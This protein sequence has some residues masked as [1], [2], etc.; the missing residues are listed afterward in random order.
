MKKTIS[1]ILALC[2][3]FAFAACGGADEEQ[4]A[5]GNTTLT[6]SW[7]IFENDKAYENP[8]YE[9]KE[10][11]TGVYNSTSEGREEKITFTYT[12]EEGTLKLAYDNGTSSEFKY[13]IEG[14]KLNLDTGKKT[15]TF[16]KK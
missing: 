13:T 3:L 5:Q 15:I 11:G 12:D 7:Y 2:M 1:I 10:D 16:I 14:D 4:S 6:G 9:F 8:T